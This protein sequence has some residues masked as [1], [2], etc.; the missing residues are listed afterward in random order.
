MVTKTSSSRTVTA[1]R[2]PMGFLA[3]F[4]FSERSSLTLNQ[5]MLSM[6]MGL[7]MG[8]QTGMLLPMEL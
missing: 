4:A 6:E 1:M 8:L 5:V 3:T 7:Q 2:I